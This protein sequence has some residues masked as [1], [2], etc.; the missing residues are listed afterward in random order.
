MLPLLTQLAAVRGDSCTDLMDEGLAVYVSTATTGTAPASM[1]ASTRAAKAAVAGTQKDA[2]ESLASSKGGEAGDGVSEASAATAASAADVRAGDADD[3]SEDAWGFMQN[4][5]SGLRQR[6]GAPGR[7]GPPEAG[8]GHQ[9]FTRENI[10]NSPLQPHIK[11]HHGTAAGN[12]AGGEGLGRGAGAGTAEGPWRG[13][14]LDPHV[15]P[16]GAPNPRSS[17]TNSDPRPSQ[18]SFGASKLHSQSMIAAAPA[19]GEGLKKGQFRPRGRRGM[20]QLKVSYD[21]TLYCWFT[22]I[23]VT[24]LKVRGVVGVHQEA[25]P[26]CLWSLKRGMRDVQYDTQLLIHR[27]TCFL[28]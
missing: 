19:K 4:A 18:Q 6:Q 14:G 10:L 12:Q 8:R 2:S 7:D 15:T 20:E 5:H 25:P 11:L 16:S 26:L 27:Y 1:V 23:Y 28:S 13:T 24:C 22:D 17:G 9:P 21:M 3:S